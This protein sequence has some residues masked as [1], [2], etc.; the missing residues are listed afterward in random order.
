MKIR[1]IILATLTA[2]IYVL[3]NQTSS[4][5]S[6]NTETPRNFILLN[7]KE[8]NVL[9]MVEDKD[10][11][12]I[13]LE[14][15]LTI[16]SESELELLSQPV[17]LEQAKLALNNYENIVVND[18]CLNLSQC[19]SVFISYEN[20]S[21]FLRVRQDILNQI[22]VIYNK[23]GS[24]YMLQINKAIVGRDSTFGSSG[25][26]HFIG[27]FNTV[28]NERIIEPLPNLPIRIRDDLQ[29]KY[30]NVSLK[31]VDLDG[32]NYYLFIDN[33][34]QK[35]NFAKVLE[36]E[37]AN[38]YF[39]WGEVKLVEQTQANSQTKISETILLFFSLALSFLLSFGLAYLYERY[40]DYSK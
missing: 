12:L 16:S 37:L 35:I 5:F 29:G 38:H 1:I 22:N 7:E 9:K 11:E 18:A 31:I 15:S 24:N 17:I 8:F 23:Y 36:E 34:E 28:T 26:F 39:L 6:P 4:S 10:K 20:E 27:N 25:I 19:L 21:E 40:K 3:L 30:E 13:Y 33:V 2:V 32:H 14:I